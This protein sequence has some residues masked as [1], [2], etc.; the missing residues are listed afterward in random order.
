MLALGLIPPITEQDAAE[1]A[2]P[3]VQH[4]LFGIVTVAIYQWLRERM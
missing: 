2:G 4:M 3:I 1:V